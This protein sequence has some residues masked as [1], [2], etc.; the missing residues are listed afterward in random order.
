[1]SSAKYDHV[2]VCLGIINNSAFF[3][4]LR[5]PRLDDKSSGP[6]ISLESRSRLLGV[7]SLRC[8][9]CPQGDGSVVG[10]GRQVLFEQNL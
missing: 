6:P 8:D 2:S 1:M 3:H 5:G 9:P 10:K 4:S 7:R